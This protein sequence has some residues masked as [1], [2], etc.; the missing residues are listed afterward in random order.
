MYEAFYKLREPPFRLTPDPTYLY[1]SKH[2]REALGHLLY[3][4]REGSGFVAITGEIGTGKTTLLRT[5]LRNLEPDTTVAYLF[6]PALSDIELLQAI[7]SE[8]ALPARSNSKKELVDELNR[9]LVDQKVAH[10]HV[11]VIVDEAQDLM[12]ATL[13]QLRLLSNLETETEKLLQIVL[14]GQPELQTMLRRSDLAQLNQRVTVRWH[15]KPLD[16]RETR[17][18]VHHRLRVAGGPQACGLFTRGALRRIYRFSRGVPRL[19]NIAAHRA[20]LAGYASERP[21]INAHTASRALLELRQG[22]EHRA[23]RNVGFA[24]ALSAAMAALVIGSAASLLLLEQ[25]PRSA[26]QP[27]AHSLDESAR[28][29][30][31]DRAAPAAAPE[32]GSTAS[33]QALSHT[34]DAAPDRDDVGL[35]LAAQAAATSMPQPPPAAS[36]ISDL[37]PA[38]PPTLPSP[39]LAG[40]DE[41]NA[42]LTSFWKMLGAMDSRSAAVAATEQLL[43]AWDTEPLR[44]EERSAQRLDL[45]TIAARR[46]LRYLPTSGTLAR[47]ELLDLPAI[48]EFALPDSGQRR[49]AVVT[50]MSANGP[51]ISRSD[52][53]TD[54]PVRD[55]ERVWLGE[56]HLFWRDFENLSPYLAPGTT[57]SEVG[58]LQRLLAR[59][60]AYPDPPS[61]VYDDATTEAIARFQR[62]RH[63]VPDGIVGPLTKIAL[64]NA[65][66]TYH[67]PRLSGGT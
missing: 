51:I 44:P 49:F 17:H 14:V 24:P 58:R 39:A 18:Y 9:F 66:A 65:I 59:V 53:A 61:L 31:A 33:S 21:R 27:F 36:P 46:G 43:A 5:L 52:G 30:R 7:N 50:G 41:T 60:G 34:A 28:A 13:E 12:P 6:N 55:M 11:V 42:S 15:L 37:P 64:Y 4:I 67:R 1:L 63:L 57:G 3:G 8:F 56:A 26:P 10:R 32:A 22:G 45:S 23:R 16:R 2:H 54:L 62:S 29:E 35:V 19:V 38:D 48:L 40:S 25:R 47:L 20:L